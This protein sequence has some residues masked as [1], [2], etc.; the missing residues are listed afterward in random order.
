MVGCRR[1]WARLCLAKYPP[2]KTK[3]FFLNTARQYQYFDLIM[4]IFVTVL[5]VSNIASSA[6]IVD[7][8]FNVFGV[9]MA[10]DAGTI[11]FP[12]SYIF[13]DILTEVYGYKNSRRV[14]WAGFA[15]LALSAV[16]FGLIRVLPGEAQWQKYAGDAAYLAI[17]GGMSSGGIVLASLAGYWS[18]EF[19]NSFVLAKMKILTR[20]R[21]LWTRTIGST[22]VGELVDT[23]VFVTIASLFKVFPWSLF[24]T[25]L[26]TNYMFKCG[27]EALMTPVTY[28]A[29]ATLKKTEHEDYYDR[30]TNFNPFS[31][32]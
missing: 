10:F 13:G 31:I 18:G 19:T 15:C 8:G 23:A 1:D 2:D 12:V 21:W 14:I 22:I 3:D 27:V 20:G 24:L 32:K 4:A 7:W 17:L 26:L 6:K 16:I 29:V 25:L 11:L 9:H 30:E 28:A 5:V